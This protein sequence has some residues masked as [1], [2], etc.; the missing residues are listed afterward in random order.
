MTNSS[1]SHLTSHISH[2]TTTD[3]CH[4]SLLE[5]AIAAS[6]NGIIIVDAGEPDRPIIYCNPGFEKLSG[7]SRDEV[8]GRNCRFLQ[9]PDTD[10]A[11]L[12]KLRSSLQAGTEI[13]VVLKNYRKD[14]TPFWNELT[15][16][17]VR[18]ASGKL[19]HFIGIQNDITERVAAETALAESEEKLQA[20]ASATPVPLLITRVEDSVIL[21]ANPVLGK[22]F[23]LSS[24][25]LV[26]CKKIDFYAN[27]S[28]RQQLLAS[29]T[30]NGFCDREQ[31]CLKKANGSLFWA[32]IS[33]RLIHFNGQEAILSTFYDITDRVEAEA[34]RVASEAKFQKL[35]AN[36]PGM[37]YQLLLHPDGSYN[38]IYVSP[39]CRELSE[40]EVEEIE[41][42]ADSMWSAVHPDDVK[43]LSKS[44]AISAETLE[45][46]K[47]EGRIVTK[48]GKIKWIRGIARPEKQS[49]GDILWDGMILDISDRK[50]AEIALGESK[51]ALIQA[52]QELEQRVI[53][54]TEALQR[55][56]Q[57][58][59]LVI[60][61]IPQ[62]IAWKDLDL[63][64]L[65]G[66]KNFAKAAGLHPNQIPGL[67]DFDLPW[68]PE[69]TEFFRAC[70]R[71][72]M[73]TNT[74]KYHIIE[75]Q[76]QADGTQ[77]WLDTNKIPLH[78][79]HGNVV[80]ILLTFEDIT[81]RLALEAKVHA[82][83]EV[84]RKIFEDAPI[85]IDLANLENRQLVQV[86]KAYCEMLGYTESEL[87]GKTF[88]D[89]VHP[90]D[91]E[92][93]M[94]GALALERQEIR[95]YQ[96]EK[97]LITGTGKIVWA[98]VTATL[99]RDGE[100]KPIYNLGMIENI[101][102]RKISEAALQASAFQL[103]KQAAQLQQAYEQLQHTQIQL[104][105]S[106]KM[107][108]LGQMVAGIAHEINNPAT[109]IQGN[110]CHAEHYFRDLIELLNLYQRCY[111]SPE[112]QIT[113][114]IEEVELEYL[115]TDLPK[116]LDSMMMGVTR[117]SKIVLSL[118]NFA[119]LDEAEMKL[120]DLHEGIESTLLIL[121]HRLNQDSKKNRIEIVKEYGEL[122]KV[123][124]CAGQLNQVFLNILSNAIDALKNQQ[125][126]RMIA[127][128]T[129][130]K[131]A[132]LET[133][134]DSEIGQCDRVVICIA[135]SGPG[136]TADIR[137]RLF[138]PFFTTKPVGSG[139]GLG[140]SI[141]YQIVVEKH[142]GTLRCISAPGQGSEFWIEIP[143]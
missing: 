69:E 5:R 112:P 14:K 41:K 77:R 50:Q 15:V 78:D 109:F 121:Q 31:I 2:R 108:S 71:Q 57:M 85:G 130:L 91:I 3:S 4:L 38:F 34:A 8:L 133:K 113:E 26:G 110:I 101:T 40:L 129:Q 107:S 52:N 98:N 139:T 60:N 59:W 56:Q 126:P 94:Q 89:L 105:H 23:G 93:N 74:P 12:S 25:Q 21:Y 7:Y 95:S 68:K 128:R 96:V 58:L 45:P 29:V 111:P 137:N 81:D 6:S 64:Y 73:E 125:Q 132:E 116:M 103:R 55:T 61:N 43:F 65:G 84:F 49:G 42:K 48:S 123:N 54:R 35:A 9:G 62:F 134:S 86:N 141:S 46:W 88:I 20:I 114:K 44:V 100:G 16:S 10:R 135:D 97:R 18:D 82:S 143:V 36:V 17:P 76:L 119:R 104:V 90:E 63:V 39:G 51:A 27:V 142:K 13:T 127:I 140:L 1:I 120:A 79:N 75:P 99:I 24:E 131:K 118:R 72:V 87:L 124:C 70:D 11:L 102:H 115:K 138:D 30:E 22:T 32:K 67:T 80:G 37:I 19:T 136:M 53:E 106:E 66:N 47:Y 92:Q 122:S 83:E 28:D 117:I 33:M